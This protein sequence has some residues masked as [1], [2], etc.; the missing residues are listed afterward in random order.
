MPLSHFL[1]TFLIFFT[2]SELTPQQ[3]S[4]SSGFL[5]FTLKNSSFGTTNT[6][7]GEAVVPLKTIPLV[8]SSMVHTVTNSYLAMNTPN[9][10]TGKLIRFLI[11]VQFIKINFSHYLCKY[12]IEI[13]IKKS[14][15]D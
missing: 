10:D 6:F 5:L 9:F 15:Q 12:L 11:M 14:L 8:E 7:V 3:D 1:F 2:T 4:V 13:L